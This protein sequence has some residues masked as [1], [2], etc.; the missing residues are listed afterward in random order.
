MHSRELL[1]DPT[2]VRSFTSRTLAYFT[3]GT[4]ESEMH[5]ADDIVL[6]P[7]SVRYRRDGSRALRALD[8]C[9]QWIANRWPNLYEYRLSHLW[10]MSELVM[11]YRVVK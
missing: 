10:P 11:A 1:S 5:Y 3:P 6:T 4:A 2:H 9:V 8:A 7:V